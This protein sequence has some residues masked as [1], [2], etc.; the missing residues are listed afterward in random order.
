[1]PVAKSKV[2]SLISDRTKSKKLMNGMAYSLANDGVGFNLICSCGKA[3]TVTE[4]AIR[5]ILKDVK[6]SAEET[7]NKPKVEIRPCS[8]TKIEIGEPLVA[9][10]RTNGHNYPVDYPVIK[11]SNSHDGGGASCLIL[12]NSLLKGGT[13]SH[14]YL[15]TG[16]SMQDRV[17]KVVAVNKKFLDSLPTKALR[18]LF[19]GIPVKNL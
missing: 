17:N 2:I 11:A 8:F 5:T 7:K 19:N 14:P 10:T 16:N 12:P 6:G 18:N 1:M 3:I 15:Y 9:T 13:R 4:A